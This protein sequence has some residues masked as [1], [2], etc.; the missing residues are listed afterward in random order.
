MNAPILVV[1]DEPNVRQTLADILAGHGFDAK[2]AE[3]GMQAVEMIRRET[4]ECAV[5]DL[6]M[7][8]MSGMETLVQ[9]KEISPD[10]EV[11]ILTG[12]PT[13]ES[14]IQAVREHVFDYLTKPV[15]SFTLVNAVTRAVERR[16][17]VQQNRD[18]VNQLQVERGKLQREFAA[19][20]RALEQRLSES[21]IFIGV[22][23]QMHQV[24]RFIA[25]VAPSDMTVLI[26]GES[27]TGKDVV[28]QLIHE[29]SGR[30]GTGAFVKINCPAIPETLL[31][32]ELF[33]HEAGAFTGAER[34][35]PGRFELAVG[36]TIFLDEIGEIPPSL[37]VKLLQVIEHK[38]FTRLGGKENIN[39]DTRILAATNAQLEHMIARSQ[40]RSDLFYRL[41]EYSIFLPPLRQRTEDIPALVKHFLHEYG[42]RYAHP[43][44][45]VTTQT[46]SMLM[47]Y[48]WPGNVRELKAVVKFYAF[49]GREDSIKESLNQA[50][51]DTAAVSVAAVMP[52]TEPAPDTASTRLRETEIRTIMAALMET[53]WNQRQ[54]AKILGISYSSLR[55]RIDKY[56]LKNR[57]L[58]YNEV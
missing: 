31:E 51:A 4:F 46:M 1:D 27:G 45:E 36:G 21:P 42:E 3:S 17:L 57:P 34:R 44:M 58:A 41:N 40:F 9:I 18:L 35:K 5:V 32:S 48:P 2:T 8:G 30:E 7:P 24:R 47:R 6:V 54:A 52:S 16:R 13:L 25:E 12:Q 29:S 23:E 11:I 19:A 10:V 26:R 49:T 37:Q 15:L 20:K 39:V 38:Q 14:T 43:D 50:G 22:S 33:G 28:S 55:R 56:D 53:K